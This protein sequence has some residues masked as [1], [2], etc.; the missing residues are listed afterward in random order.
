MVLKSLVE[1]GTTSVTIVPHVLETFTELR[2]KRIDYD[3]RAKG[4]THKGEVRSA[5]DE[6]GRSDGFNQSI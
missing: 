2:A 6:R 3:M 1:R 4:N 5:A